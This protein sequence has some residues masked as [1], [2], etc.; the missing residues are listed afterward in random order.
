MGNLI[1]HGINAYQQNSNVQPK[2]D[3]KHKPGKKQ[4][5]EPQ[6]Q[7]RLIKTTKQPGIDHLPAPKTIREK[8]PGAQSDSK[9]R[10]AAKFLII[11]GGDQAAKI[12][13]ELD[14]EQVEN[15]SREIALIKTVKPDEA[16]EIFR[17]FQAQ[18]SLPYRHSG[19]S[20]GGVDA[21][22]RILYAAMGPAKGEAMLNKAVPD[23][24][25]NI[26]DF[27][28]EFTPGQIVTLLKNETPQ[29]AALILSR[30]PRNISAATISKMP[31]QKRPQIIKRI[32][33]QNEVLPEVLEQVAAAL[34]ERVR[35]IAGG[36]RD[37]EVDGMQRLVAIL[38]QTDYAFGDKIVN[39]LESKRPD[40][41]K[42]L[43]EKLYTLDDVIFCINR[44]LQEKLK[45]M[46]DREI[47]ILI[48]GRK[49]EFREKI[50]DCVSD[51]RKKIIS[52]E[53]EI[54]GVM[55]R[56]DC[57]AVAKEFLTWFRDAREKG[58]II[59]TTDED[60]YV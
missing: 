41:G 3:N 46:N 57:D 31:T 1:R 40:I 32:A 37:I 23:S 20:H 18:F 48:K 35:N 59:L 52:E 60:V 28:L 44:P 51:R 6:N 29:T 11:I 10:R 55:L 53:E 14:P 39:E 30:L 36:A 33:L 25:E 15:I 47:A 8:Q 26:F 24:K 50:L 38:K 16:N 45:D 13:A 7:Q 34:K 54:L 2:G 5:T 4:E 58:E 42:D 12:L 49:I 9:Y 27:L 19:L 56:R 43:K 17:E 22:R 21:A